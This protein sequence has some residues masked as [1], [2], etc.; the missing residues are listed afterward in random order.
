M[1]HTLQYVK[2]LNYVLSLSQYL[3]E[4]NVKYEK[5]KQFAQETILILD[6]AIYYPINHPNNFFF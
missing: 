6:D 5:I 2:S 4:L 3:D 1:L